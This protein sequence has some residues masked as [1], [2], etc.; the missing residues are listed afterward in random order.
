LKESQVNE[1]ELK[2]LE[3][4]LSTT[5]L[6]MSICFFKTEQYQKAVEKATA[7]LGV[8]RSVKGL[9]RRAQA[10]RF[11]KD[12]ESALKDLEEALTL[13]TTAEEDTKVTILKE[14]DLNKQMDKEYDRQTQKKM[15]GFL[16]K[17]GLSDD[18]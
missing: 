5:F 15:Q 6:N 17:G 12:Y 10:N 7:S 14:L 3:E 4:L 13:I 18:K 16:L 11:R 9:Y 2:V 1:D 8:K